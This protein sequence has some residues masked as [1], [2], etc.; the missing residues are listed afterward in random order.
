[1][2]VAAGWMPGA[3]TIHH[4]YCNN[5]AP[6]VSEGQ[7]PGHGRLRLSSSS[8]VIA[9]APAWISNTVIWD[10]ADFHLI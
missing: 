4:V 1:M 3:L 5:K 7:Q 2:S 9:A 6:I 8:A 10:A